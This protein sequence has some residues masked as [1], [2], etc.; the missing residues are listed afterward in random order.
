MKKP[1]IPAKLI[2][3]VAL[4]ALCPNSLFSKV[5]MKNLQDAGIISYNVFFWINPVEKYTRSSLKTLMT[6][7]SNWLVSRVCF[8]PCSQ[9]WNAGWKLSKIPLPKKTK[10]QIPK[11]HN[12]NV[13]VYYFHRTIMEKIIDR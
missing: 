1:V 2:R 8:A 6:C 5:L 7:N 11:P 9:I 4:R 12:E 10:F 3:D 13:M